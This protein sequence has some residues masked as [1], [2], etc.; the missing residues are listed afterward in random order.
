MSLR[1]ICHYQQNVPQH[2]CL[3]D[4]LVLYYNSLL[5]NYLS[6]I[7][8]VVAFGRLKTKENLKILA[9][10]VVAVAYERWPLTTGSKYRD[11]TGKRLV[12]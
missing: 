7:R 2:Y 12:F 10:E 1:K 5:S 11:L 9:R 4:T 6:I 3:L 8:Q